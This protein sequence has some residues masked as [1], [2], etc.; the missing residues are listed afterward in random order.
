MKITLKDGSLK[1]YEKNMSV[2]ILQKISAKVWQE[3]QLAGKSK[4]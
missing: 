4:W 3:W 1:E 2:L